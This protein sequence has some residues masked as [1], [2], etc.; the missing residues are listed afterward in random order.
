MTAASFRP[1][2][3]DAEASVLALI[4]ASRRRGLKAE[5]DPAI[6]GGVVVYHKPRVV[7]LRL[8][9]NHWYRPAPDQSGRSVPVGRRGAEDFLARYLTDEL[10]GHR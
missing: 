9:A 4:S 3:S 2:S 8:M 10:M 7:T 6:D 1:V 5:H